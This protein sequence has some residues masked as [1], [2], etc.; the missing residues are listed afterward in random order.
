MLAKIVTL[1]SKHGGF[2]GQGGL[3]ACRMKMPTRDRDEMNSTIMAHAHL[4]ASVDGLAQSRGGDA[5]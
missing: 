5:E 2:R 3:L 1:R 4:L